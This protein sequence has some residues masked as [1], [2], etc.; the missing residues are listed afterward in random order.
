MPCDCRESPGVLLR[1]S[2]LATGVYDEDP[3]I[4]PDGRRV[5]F[6][7]NVDSEGLAEIGVVDMDG[8]GERIL[9]LGCSDPCVGVEAPNWT[10]DGHHLVYGRIIGPIDPTN[11]NAVGEPLYRSGLN[12]GLHTRLTSFDAVRA[13]FAPEGYLVFRRVDPNNHTAS[14][15]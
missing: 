13:S 14:S 3:K 15:A 8:R 7:R 1:H 4:S 5:L 6:E 12:S 10:P 11:G 9:D 2:R